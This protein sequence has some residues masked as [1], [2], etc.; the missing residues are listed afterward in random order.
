ML[1]KRKKIDN[2]IK[3]LKD[4]CFENVFNPYVHNCDMHDHN[5]SCQIREANLNAYLN[6]HLNFNSEIIWVGR[7]LGYRGGRRT[8][9]PLT[10][11][12][13][14]VKLNQALKT[15]KISK[16]TSSDSVNEMTAR[17]I[18]KMVTY[19]SSPP[20][21]WNVFPYHPFNPSNTMSNRCHSKIEFK[22]GKKILEDVLNIFQFKYYFALG[23]DAYSA[24]N[25]MGL[26]PIYVRHPSHG[27]Q[28]EFR[29]TIREETPRTH[30][31]L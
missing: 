9:I 16:A 6:H 5:V 26:N 19:L 15:T 7:D 11:E 25:N 3:V 29:K 10:D 18:W 28:K 21:F 13:H 24:L 31:L 4:T 14:L 12:I 8:G 20:F 30:I 17:E 23:R 2:L 22:A 27:G 1:K